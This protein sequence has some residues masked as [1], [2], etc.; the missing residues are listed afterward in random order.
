YFLAWRDIKVRYKQTALG[1][2]WAIL[3][4]AATVAI[5][6]I[7]FGRLAHLE[8][9]GAPYPVFAFAGLLP[10]N[11]FQGGLNQAANSLVG[12]SNLLTKVYFPRMMLPLANIVCGLVDFAFAFIVMLGLMICYGIM[13]GARMLWLPLP[14]ILALT[15]S[16]G[17]GL[18]LSAMNV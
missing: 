12:N 16:L 15:A 1:I 4:P 13:P 3:Q 9:D 5:F 11:F 6:S 10:W 14:L 17:A 18:W 8:S 2:L 7:F